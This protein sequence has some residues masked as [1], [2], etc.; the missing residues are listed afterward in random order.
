M[1][2]KTREA[3]IQFGITRKSLEAVLIHACPH[4]GAPGVY[5]GDARTQELWPGCWRAEWH[6]RPVGDVCPNC[7]ESRLKDRNLGELTA[8]LPKWIWLGILAFKWC[9]VT[10]ITLKRSLLT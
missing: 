4:C 7:H 8:S 3:N 5:K 2:A 9:V 10:S 6:D 1:N